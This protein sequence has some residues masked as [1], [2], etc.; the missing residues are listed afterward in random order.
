M[1]KKKMLHV[2]DGT[3]D[4]LAEIAKHMRCVKCGAD[5]PPAVTLIQKGIKP[6]D[7]VA[8]P[9]LVEGI[10]PPPDGKARAMA[11]ALCASCAA[12]LGIPLDDR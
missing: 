2:K 12:I 1:E 5:P 7:P 9:L 11:L 6:E 10:A 4:E 3:L 8:L